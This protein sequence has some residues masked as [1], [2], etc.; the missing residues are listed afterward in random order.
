MT[1]MAG[2]T[3]GRCGFKDDELLPGHAPG[4]RRAGRVQLDAVREYHI[5]RTVV[6]LQ[7]AVLA[8][9]GDGVTT[10]PP[11]ARARGG[12]EPSRRPDRFLDKE[13]RASQTRGNRR[14]GSAD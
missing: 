5:P 9:R 14:A 7:A 1:G 13:S 10:V 4:G 6:P 2:S 3:I 8:T 12:R 11:R